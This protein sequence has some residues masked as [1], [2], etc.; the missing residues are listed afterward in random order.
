MSHLDRQRAARLMRESDVDALVLFQPENFAYATGAAPGVAA[1]WR[2]AGGAVAIVPSNAARV[3][4]IVGD[5]NATA[6][7][8]QSPDLN[9][10]SHRLWVDTVDVTNVARDGRSAAAIVADAYARQSRA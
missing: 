10:R 4:A 8:H 9:V 2:R 3:V 7:A 5:L 1:M 6:V